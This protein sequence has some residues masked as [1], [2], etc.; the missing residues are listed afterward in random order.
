MSKAFTYSLV[1][2]DKVLKGLGSLPKRLKDE[3]RSEVEGAA[4]RIV[5]RAV[6]D[7]GSRG[8][9]GRAKAVNNNN[10]RL[11]ISKFQVGDLTFEIVSN[12]KYSAYV[13]FGT[14]GLVSIPKGLEQYASQFK[15]KGVRKVNLPARPFFFNNFEIERVKLI[16]RLKNIIK[17]L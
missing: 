16:Q 5:D 17:D 3:V 8:V 4:Q 11:G 7:V 15:G 13:E 10:L 2:A 1:G 12:A 14:G 6:R 9:G